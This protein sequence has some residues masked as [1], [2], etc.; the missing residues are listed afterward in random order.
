[1]VCYYNFCVLGD[2]VFGVSNTPKVAADIRRSF[3]SAG[4][5]ESYGHFDC[6]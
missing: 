4:A 2:I 6:V 3:K 1:M 5:L